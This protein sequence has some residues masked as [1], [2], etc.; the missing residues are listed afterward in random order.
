MSEIDFMMTLPSTSFPDLEIKPVRPQLE[1]S[2]W[3]M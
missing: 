2:F 1:I 3:N